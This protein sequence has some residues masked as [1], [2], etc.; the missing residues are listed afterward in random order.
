MRTL[1]QEDWLTSAFLVSCYIIL[2]KLFIMEDFRQSQKYGEQYNEPLCN[3]HPALMIANLP[4]AS[5]KSIFCDI[6]IPNY[7]L[8]FLCALIPFYLPENAS[9]CLKN[10][11][12]EFP[13][14]LWFLI[15]CH[16]LCTLIVISHWRS[17]KTHLHRRCL[18]MRSH[19][20][21]PG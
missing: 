9:S 8:L 16:L 3:Y 11:T 6:N 12:I 19:T 5:P 21:V 4:S 14:R 17:T 18:W 2:L 15:S 10:G 1:S 13:D 7:F 20:G